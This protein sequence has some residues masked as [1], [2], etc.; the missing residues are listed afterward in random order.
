MTDESDPI[1]RGLNEREGIEGAKTIEE[2]CQFDNDGVFR[3]EATAETDVVI[4][5]LP[6]AVIRMLCG[7]HKVPSRVEAL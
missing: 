5:H 1:R 6:I 3:I 2:S 4:V 7:L